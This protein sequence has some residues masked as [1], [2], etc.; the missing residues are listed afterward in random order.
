MI[1]RVIYEK[2]HNEI[3][4]RYR[5]KYADRNS[6]LILDGI[7][8]IENYEGILFLL[9]EAYANEQEFDEW[10]LAQ[11]LAAT[12]PWGMW[13]H[14]AKWT[15]GLLN[16]DKDHIARYCNL[17]NDDRNALLRKISVVNVKK[18]NGTSSSEYEDLLQYTTSN[19]EILR[20]EINHVQPKIIVCG[21][22]FDFLKQI[23]GLEIERSNDNWYYW[24][25]L[26]NMK[27]I[28]VLDYFHPAVRYPELLT[29]YG[30]TNIY[31][32]ALLAK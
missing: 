13:H 10:D 27:N 25:D 24:L 1:N 11:G 30:L 14:V 16:T 12:G 8:D 26:E 9:K 3:Y 17:S 20:R 23:Y 29:Y 32:Q 7:V 19:I 28:L 5:E 18:V 21:G 31:Q 22:T 2:E 4:N 15:Y 6:Y